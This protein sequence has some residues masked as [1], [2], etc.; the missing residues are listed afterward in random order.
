MGEVLPETKLIVT[1]DFN[2][3]KVLFVN[4]VPTE[5]NG[6]TNVI[7]NLIDAMD[8]SDIEI[9]F[10]AISVP[11]DFYKVKL[12]NLGCKL[13]IIPRKIFSPIK[14]IR[15]LSNVAKGY[16]IVHAHGNSATMVL[17]MIAAA[18][19]NVPLRIA[20]AHSTSCSHK[21]ID[22]CA[23]PLFYKLCNIRLACG[24]ASGKWL[25][26]TL[27]FTII[28]NG[29]NT[30]RFKFNKI[31]RDLIRT[32]LNLNDKMVLG[33][34]GNFVEAKNHEFLI[35]IFAEYQKINPKSS[36]LL[37]G[38]GP[39]KKSIEE[40]S[41]DLGIYENVYFLG[42]IEN[43]EDFLS[44]IDIIIMPSIFEGFPLTLVEEQAN[45][46]AI[47][48]SSVITPDTN[49]TGLIQ[50]LPLTEDEEEWAKMIDKQISSIS[51]RSE[52]I[53]DAAISNIKKKGY[54]I[55]SIAKNLKNIYKRT[56]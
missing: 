6:I 47:L 36:L 33:H 5:Q 9:G 30:S 23:R 39:L 3:M 51:Q 52:I 1:I 44:A 12:K 11:Q 17:E 45:G 18:L 22:I 37:I 19:A 28:H 35:K 21:I 49:L 4:T 24:I 42:N 41:K 34:V 27:P 7:F 29:I 48:A 40:L 25:Y 15:Q 54:D 56:L 20:H 8:L 53:S 26:K 2:K 16:D 31:K 13:H 10:V 46:L 32:N 50:Y 43:P 38:S 55:K 14:Y